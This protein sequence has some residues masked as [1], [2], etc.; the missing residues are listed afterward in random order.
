MATKIQRTQGKAT[1]TLTVGEKVYT[2]SPLTF[3][4]FG[5]M[6]AFVCSLRGDPIAVATEASAEVPATL[7]PMLWDAAVRAAV[8]AKIVP[9]SEMANF[10]KSMA[11][12][13]WKLWKCLEPKHGDEFKTHSDALALLTTIGKDRFAEVMAKISV[14]SGEEDLKK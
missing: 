9:A 12:I 3:G 2:L 7:Q 8:Y 13:G 10:E 6:E 14:V 5:E 4:F 1:E 11:G